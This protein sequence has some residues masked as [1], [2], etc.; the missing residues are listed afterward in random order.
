MR[1]CAGNAS[2]ISPGQGSAPAGRVS[3]SARDTAA[4]NVLSP[5]PVSHVP[6]IDATE[7]RQIAVRPILSV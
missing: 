4:R 7:W 2:A 5:A 3:G 1:N 6:D